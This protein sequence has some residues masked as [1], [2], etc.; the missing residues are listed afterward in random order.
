MKKVNSNQKKTTLADVMKI[1]E[2]LKSG[3][4]LGQAENEYV[5]KH[6]KMFGLDKKTK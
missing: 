6:K 5:Q 4:K 3:K 2:Q 1:K